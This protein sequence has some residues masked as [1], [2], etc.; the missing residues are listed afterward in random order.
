MREAR[1]VMAEL[2]ASGLSPDQLALVMELAATV[3]AESRPTI[4]KAAENKRA[5]DRD[6]QRQIRRDRTMSYESNDLPSLEVSPQTPLPK[7]S[8]ESAP[9]NPPKSKKR[10]KA[11]VV[12]IPEWMPP[13][14]WLAFVAHRKAMRGIPFTDAAAKGVIAKVDGLRKQGHCPEKLLLK[15]VMHG[16]RTV[17]EAEDTKAAAAKPTQAYVPKNAADFER[18]ASFRE[19]VGDH[20]EAQKLRATAAKLRGATGPP[21][22]IGRAVSEVVARVGG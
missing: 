17:F 15:A 13:E 8:P 3:S 16:W 5:Y 2:A 14:P 7:P 11:L 19:S 22:P 20:D 6:R 10:E 21:R 4:D 12:Q 9:L 1:T 18:V